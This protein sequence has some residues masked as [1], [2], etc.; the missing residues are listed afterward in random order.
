MLD[1]GAA[2]KILQISEATV[3][4]WSRS[5]MLPAASTRPLRFAP[6]AVADLRR[7]LAAGTVDR[8]NRRAN[9]LHRGDPVRPADR[10]AAAFQAALWLDLAP[11]DRRAIAVRLLELALALTVSRG[12]ASAPEAALAGNFRR[13]NLATLFRQWSARLGS[14]SPQLP[15][16]R[17]LADRLARPGAPAFP[18]AAAVQFLASGGDRSRRGAFFTPPATIRTIAAELGRSGQSIL[19][20]ACGTG[21]FL[22]GFL[23]E[24][25]A[26]LADLHGFDIDPDTVD[27]ARLNLLLHS[28]EERTMPDIRCLDALKMATGERFDLVVGNPPWG[29]VFDRPAAARRWPELGGATDSFAAFLALG[30]ELAKP[31]GRISLL[32]PESL[33]TVRR[34]RGCRNYLEARAETEPARPLGRIFRGV[35]TPALRLDFRPLPFAP[36][37]PPPLRF[38]GGGDRLVRELLA[39]PHRTLA[40]HAEFMIGIVTGDNRRLLRPAPAAGLEPVWR[41]SGVLPFRFDRPAGYLKFDPATFQQ[42]APAWKYR[43]PEK[44]VYR[45]IGGKLVF[46]RDDRQRLTLNSANALIPSLPG[47]GAGRLAA[48]LNSRLANAFFRARFHELKIL[49]WHLE[50]MPI[51]D[52]LTAL[53]PEIDDLILRAERGEAYAARIEAIIAAAAAEYVSAPDVG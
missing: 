48:W 38:A 1:T 44:L 47:I 4:N 37:A 52:F 12:E 9:K 21:D 15:H 28:E 26:K 41:G 7:R 50:N 5:G 32:V 34:H 16:I 35:L 49:R 23:R 29:G 30:L 22:L 27:F 42:T 25:G 51:P 11:A 31:A 43:A 6:A 2:A 8:L 13:G 45:F 18:G 46:A 39:A 10:T 24:G 3:R 19:D 53:P 20:P 14:P 40:G 17:R 33:L 36:A